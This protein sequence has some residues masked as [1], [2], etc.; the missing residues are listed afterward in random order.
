MSI[1]KLFGKEENFRILK[2]TSKQDLTSSIESEAFASAVVER[3]EAFIPHVDF[4]HPENF[5]RYGSAEEYYKNSVAR[6]Y[7][8]Y[9]YDGSLREKQL[10]HLSSSYLDEYIFAKRYPRATGYAVFSLGASGWGTRVSN[11]SGSLGMYGAPATAS[12]EYITVKG[13]PHPNSNDLSAKNI[14]L[15]FTGSNLYH[16]ASNRESNLRLN[17]DRG[18]TLEFWLR[19]ESFDV[20]NKTH[21]EVIFD[22]WNGHQTSSTTSDPAYGRLRLELSGTENGESPFR[23]TLLS[24]ASNVGFSNQVIGSG[25]TTSSVADNTWSHYAVSLQNDGNGVRSKF[26]VTGALNQTALFGSTSVGEITG[27][28]IANI[29]ALRSAP[30]GASFVGRSMEGHG[31]LS[32]SLDELR[33]W[34][35]RRTSEQIGRYWFTQI[36]GGT[37]TDPP[38]QTNRDD[39][40]NTHLGVYYKF[41]EGTTG[42]SDIDSNV[43][44][45]SGRISNGTW[46]GYTSGA[47][48]AGSALNEINKSGTGSVEFRDPII[49]SE[50]P[51][52]K[53]LQYNLK[54]TGSVYDREN[55]ASIY[56][57]FPDWIVDDDD[58]ELLKL[59][60]VISSYFDTLHLQVEA[61]PSLKNVAYNPSASV[62][63]KPYPFT[64]R[65]LHQKYLQMPAY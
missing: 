26:Y 25:I 33:Y 30:S 13:G 11:Y 22:L 35:A 50:H 64:D 21:R 55:N 63:Y 39:D 40:A 12:Y 16:T 52:V 44:D 45:Y 57:S 1:K 18:V 41:N 42:Y 60:Q 32:G 38:F 53:N 24:G 6:I 15:S 62:P 5:A 8:T 54:S 7:R 29:G 61:L 31:K 17:L 56:Y 37:N 65:M 20:S 9:P 3:K 47:R 34:K 19:K 10:W 49:Y 4:T 59:T 43:L 36:G 2:S 46:T 48:I 27:S 28:L 23:L 14:V 51:D 58:G